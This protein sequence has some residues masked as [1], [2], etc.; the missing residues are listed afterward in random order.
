[1]LKEIKSPFFRDPVFDGAADPVV[2]WNREEK[3]WWLLYTNRRVNTPSQGV[4]WVHGTDIGIASSKDGGHTWVYRGILPLKDINPGRNTF[5]APEVIFENGRYHVYVSYVKGVP[6][7]WGHQRFIMHYSGTDLWE[8]KYESTLEL[9]SDKCIDA[10]VHKM[11]N[12][13]YGLWYKDERHGSHTYMVESEDLYTWN[14]PKPVIEVFNHEGPN[15]FYWKDRYFMIVDRWKGQGVFVSEDCENWTQLD[16]ILAV[17][18]EEADDFG[19]GLHA[20]VLVQGEE[21]YVVYFTH[22]GRKMGE[23]VPYELQRSS[24]QMRKLGFDGKNIICDRNEKFVYD[25]QGEV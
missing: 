12:G 24:I 3:E 16:D 2:I 8:L 13:K 23:T 20:D 11:P 5:W 21:A 25:W 6:A 19:N 1:M 7:D 9:S 14:N 4:E 17:S 10:C 22:P 15:V 18:G